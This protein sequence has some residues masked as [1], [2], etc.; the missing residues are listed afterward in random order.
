MPNGGLSMA[1]CLQATLL[2]GFQLSSTPTCV[3]RSQQS[4][5]F[6]WNYSEAAMRADPDISRTLRETPFPD[7]SAPN[8]EAV[9]GWSA[10]RKAAKAL[11]MRLLIDDDPTR[12]VASKAALRAWQQAIVEEVQ[13]WTYSAFQVR[14]D[15]Q[16]GGICERRK[17][18]AQP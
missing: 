7:G 6:H 16:V 8:K 18:V 10:D 11:H 9:G 2:S 14:R 3:L 4:S 5:L 1:L 12:K 13:S 17:F 15:K